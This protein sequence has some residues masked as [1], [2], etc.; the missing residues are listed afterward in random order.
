MGN[1]SSQQSTPAASAAVTPSSIGS[2]SSTTSSAATFTAASP[3]P[4]TQQQP[5]D[6]TTSPTPTSGSI[7]IYMNSTSPAHASHTVALPPIS[8]MLSSTSS[9]SL[10]RV[11]EM[12]L[13]FNGIVGDDEYL[14]QLAMSYSNRR[15]WTFLRA[16]IDVKK[17]KI[18]ALTHCL[19]RAC[20]AVPREVTFTLNCSYHILLSS[21]IDVIMS[22]ID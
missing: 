7:H 6:A 10:L 5:N 21:I 12:S 13:D 8:S 11:A 18:S 14:S 19:I 2:P 3:S 9:L 16:F 1:K 20:V 17:V 4:A 22:T 15:H